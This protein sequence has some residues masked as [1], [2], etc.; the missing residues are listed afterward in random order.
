MRDGDTILS[1]GG[2]FELGFFSLGNSKNRYLGIWY[3]KISNRTVVWVANRDAPLNSTSGMFQVS[4]DGILQLLSDGDT[5]WSSSFVSLRNIAP[6]AQLLDNGNLVVRDEHSTDQQIFIWQSFDYPG[7]TILPGMKFGKDLVTGIDRRWMS[8]KSLDDPSP[9]RY[10]AWMDTNGFPQI[11]VGQGKDLHLRFGPWNGNTFSGMPKLRANP[12]SVN[13]FVINEREIYFRFEV[14]SS[15]ITRIYMNPEGGV[16]RMNWV[17]RSQSWFPILTVA[18]IDSCSPYGVCGPYATCNPNNLPVCSCMGGFEPKRPEEWNVSYWS[19]GCLRRTS[20]DCGSGDGFRRI[21]GVKFPDTRRSWYNLSMTLGECEMACTMNCSCTA[22]ANIYIRNG[23]SGCLLWF[24]ELMDL[25][26]CDETQ[27][28]YIRMAVSELSSL[29]TLESGSN[30]KKRMIIAF[31]STSIFL[32]LVGLFLAMHAR[33]KKKRSYMNRQDSVNEGRKGDA[34][35]PSFSL[36]K[37]AKS[38]SNFSITNKLGEGG[39]GP[40]YKGVLGGWTRN[41]CEAIVKN[42]YTRD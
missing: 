16:A 17:N 24:D 18:P 25:R 14:D 37:I 6:V 33:N 9:G 1:D 39:F 32:V 5:I 41:S 23:G 35:L 20:L 12:T 30:N 13:V 27:S 40:V 31:V 22:Y 4:S 38:T 8:W 2:M 10:T 19:S 34:E 3:K 7:D 26:D 42:F 15:I 11:F 29:T 28:F 36:S 21:S